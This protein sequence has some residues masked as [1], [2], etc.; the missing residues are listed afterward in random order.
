ML[1]WCGRVM[2]AV[3]C[4]VRCVCV[5]VCVRAVGMVESR[6]PRFHPDP[7]PLRALEL[8]APLVSAM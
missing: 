2:W 8:R 3:I 1:A 4:G 5:C 7:L 6:V